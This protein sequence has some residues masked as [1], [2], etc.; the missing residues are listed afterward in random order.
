MVQ[1]M[2]IA[3]PIT[4]FVYLKDGDKGS[5][6]LFLDHKRPI[7]TPRVKVC[8]FLEFSFLTW[9]N[10]FDDDL[11]VNFFFTFFIQISISFFLIIDMIQI[12]IS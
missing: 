9:Y 1:K 3:L 11:F 7:R 6:S 2:A 12:S 4:S 5:Y 10:S 8:T